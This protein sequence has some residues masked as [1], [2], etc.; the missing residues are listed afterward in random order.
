MSNECI[1]QRISKFTLGIILL[2]AALGLVVIGVTLL[3]IIGLVA[4]VPVAA[5]AV[6]FFRV[7]LNDQCEIDFSTE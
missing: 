1:P 4:A 6:Y 2:G 3:P 5:L 7:H